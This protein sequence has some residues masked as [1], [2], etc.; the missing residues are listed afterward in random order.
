MRSRMHPKYYLAPEIFEGEQQKVL[1]KVWLFTG[2]KTLLTKHNAFITRKIA[3]IPVVFQN[4]HG[5]LCAFKNGCLHRSVL[6]KPF[7]AGGGNA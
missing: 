2:R 6:L 1:R 7:V 4:F 5:E 3:G